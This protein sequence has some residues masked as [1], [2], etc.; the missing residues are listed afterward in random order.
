MCGS[1]GCG[2]MADNFGIGQMQR[3]R[4][5]TRKS[6]ATL[7]WPHAIHR[8]FRYYTSDPVASNMWLQNDEDFMDFSI[9]PEVRP[10]EALC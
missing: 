2:D 8:S 7:E 9:D 5:K 3:L 4:G 1:P 10:S 6:H